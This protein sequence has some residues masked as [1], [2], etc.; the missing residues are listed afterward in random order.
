LFSNEGYPNNQPGYTNLSTTVHTSLLSGSDAI[1]GADYHGVEVSRTGT[2]RFA[3]NMLTFMKPTSGS[4]PTKTAGD[5]IDVG[6]VQLVG[7]VDEDS[8]LIF[9]ALWRRPHQSSRELLGVRAY[10]AAAN[11]T[12]EVR[13]DQVLALAADDKVQIG[14]L[15]SNDVDC[16]ILAGSSYSIHQLR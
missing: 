11:T 14:I 6:V 13:I 2:Y 10:R 5:Y 16:M 4:P 1:D 7:S 3:A 15:V 12:T 9:V 8:P